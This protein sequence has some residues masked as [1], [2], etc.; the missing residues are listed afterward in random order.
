MNTTDNNK[1][2]LQSMNFSFFPFVQTGTGGLTSISACLILSKAACRVESAAAYEIRIH[3]SSP[4]A[5]PGTRATWDHPMFY[6]Y[7]PM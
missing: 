5:S 6:Y 7:K 2:L 3:V 1:I 4:N